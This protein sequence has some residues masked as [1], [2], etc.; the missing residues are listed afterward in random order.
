MQVTAS[1]LKIN[2]ISEKN[3]TGEFV[4]EPLPKGFGHTLGNSLKRILLTSLE[5]SAITQVKFSKVDH[6]FTTIPGVKEDVVEISLNLK[7]VRFKKHSNEPIAASINVTGP[8]KVTAKD[9]DVPADLE[10]INKDLHIATLS[11]KNTT[12]KADLVIESGVGYSPMEERQSLKIGVIVLDALFSPVSHTTY[13]VE[14][15]R[16]GKVADLDKVVMNVETDGSLTPT[17]AVTESAKILK[18]FYARIGAWDDAEGEED[19]EEESGNDKASNTETVSIEE[20]PLPTR[21]INALR[22][23]GIDTLDALANK[24]DDELADIKNLGE[25]SV[26]EIKKLLKKEGL[27]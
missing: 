24:S 14:S 23:Q 13:N 11:D 26:V 7:K 16:F 9:I 27:R 10:V 6:Q 8:G 21:T 17:E 2:T 3:N 1:D 18:D 4:I 22:K 25:K 19:E 5:G 20:L 12:L 15:T